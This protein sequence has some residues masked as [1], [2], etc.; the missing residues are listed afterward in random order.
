MQ[1]EHCSLP[2]EVPVG[3]CLKGNCVCAWGTQREPPFC[4]KDDLFQ[5]DG[6][7]WLQYQ[8]LQMCW[9]DSWMMDYK[10]I[11]FGNIEPFYN[12]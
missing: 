2:K 8:K 7:R 3:L 1:V 12:R 9:D 5:S 4:R 11:K 6:P 10:N